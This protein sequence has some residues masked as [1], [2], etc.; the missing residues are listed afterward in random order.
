MVNHFLPK[1]SKFCIFLTIG[2]C[3]NLPACGPNTYQKCMEKFK[4]SYFSIS[5]G[6]IKCLIGK[7]IFGTANFE[8][9]LFRVTVANA[10]IGSLKSLP[11]LFDMCR[12]T[13]WWNLNKIV[14]SYGQ[15]YKKISFVTENRVYLKLLSTKLWRY[16]G[17]YFCSWNNCWMLNC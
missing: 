8:L 6:N 9:K 14:K 10:N 12:T 15:K 17:R 16:L 5:N 11:T 7:W 1:S 4:A 2:F 13:C 3:S